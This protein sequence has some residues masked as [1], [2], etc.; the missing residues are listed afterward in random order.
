MAAFRGAKSHFNHAQANSNDQA[1][2]NLALGLSQLTDALDKRLKKIERSA[3]AA[4]NEA[5]KR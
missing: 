5:R 4:Y 2:K 1:I 3:A